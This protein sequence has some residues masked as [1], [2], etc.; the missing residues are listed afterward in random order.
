MRLEVPTTT[1]GVVPFERIGRVELPGLGSPR[2]VVARL[3]R[4]WGLRPR[5]GRAGRPGDVRRRPLSR[6]HRQGR[7]PRGRRRRARASTSTSPTSRRARTTRP[8]CARSPRPATSCRSSSP[9]ASSTATSPDC[10]TSGGYRLARAVTWGERAVWASAMPISTMTPPTICASV[11]GTRRARP[12]RRS[13]R[14]PARSSRRRPTC[15][16]GRCASA[17]IINANGMIVPPMMMSEAEHPD[18]RRV[19]RSGC[20]AATS[21]P[22]QRPRERPPRLEHRPEQRGEAKSQTYQRDRV[23]VVPDLLLAE[24]EVERQREGGREARRVRRSRRASGRPRPGRRTRGRTARARGPTTPAGVR[25]RAH[26]SAPTARRAGER[27]TR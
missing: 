7:R 1:D 11:Q 15:V 23:P 10:Q 6:R 18:G 2:R 13:W 14:R 24:D 3:V 19:C 17:P 27:C 26:R 9:S 5:Q 4:R 22:E 16:A 20:R 25:A 12:T 21:A 8:G